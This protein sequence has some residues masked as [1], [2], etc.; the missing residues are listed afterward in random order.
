ML[1]CYKMTCMSFFGDRI[2]EWLEANG[3]QQKD[4]AYD[5]RWDPGNISK[6]INGGHPTKGLVEALIEHDPWGVGEETIKLWVVIDKLG[7]EK[8]AKAFKEMAKYNPQI[9]AERKEAYK[10]AGKDAPE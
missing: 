5:I 8:L 7:P 10:R 9:A 6:V 2:S 3:K 1:T 4:L